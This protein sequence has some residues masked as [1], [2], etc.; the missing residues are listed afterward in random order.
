MFPSAQLSTDP[1]AGLVRSHQLN[2]S[3]LRRA[4]KRAGSRAE[5]PK[6]VNSHA[7]RHS[8]ATH[9]LKAGY[10]IRTVQ[11][12]LGHADVSSIMIEMRALNRPG[13]VPVRSPVDAL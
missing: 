9:L 13:A 7:L 4:L 8:Y 3:G 10:E 6:R 1:K 2:E 12:L 5:L 11:D